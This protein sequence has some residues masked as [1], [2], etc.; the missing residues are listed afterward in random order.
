MPK[1][2]WEL[3]EPDLQDLIDQKV[4]ESLELEYKGPDALGATDG[5]KNEISKDVSA[6]ANS[7]GGTIIYGIVESSGPPPRVPVEMNGVN[8]STYSKE[9]LEQVIET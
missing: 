3:D 9:W 6:F 1:E 4:E 8:P 7:A 5:K 2:P